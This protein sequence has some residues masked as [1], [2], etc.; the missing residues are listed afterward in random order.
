MAAGLGNFQSIVNALTTLTSAISKLTQQTG[1]TGQ[2][3]PIPN[4]GTGATSASGARAALGLGSAA[5]A[6]AS[7]PNDANVASVTGSVTVGHLAVFADAGGSVEDG[8]APPAALNYEIG[9]WT[10]TLAFGGASTGIVYGSVVGAYTAIGR[11]VFCQFTLTL[12]AVGS[13]TGAAAIGGLPFASNGSLANNGSGG[14]LAPWSGMSGLTGLPSLQVGAGS[15]AASI[16][17][18]GAAASAA[19]TNSNFTGNSVIAGSF[20]YFT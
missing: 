1:F 18:P 6:A 16:L 4:G 7:N 5:Q 8:G 10:P 15:S 12:T 19:V 3:V 11:M 13:A 20:S 2:I 9:T 14:T 17:Q